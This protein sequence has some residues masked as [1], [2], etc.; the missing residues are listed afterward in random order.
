MICCGGGKYQMHFHTKWVIAKLSSTRSWW[1]TVYH[2]THRDRDNCYYIT[3]IHAPS[4]RLLRYICVNQPDSTFI[5]YQKANHRL[6]IR[7][8]QDLLHVVRDVGRCVPITRHGVK[9][10]AD[11]DT[12]Y[13]HRVNINIISIRRRFG[14]ERWVY[15]DM[16]TQATEGLTGRTK[17]LKSC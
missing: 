6:K 3:S 15:W 17:R 16:P 9:N 13:D 5:C 11:R 8:Y 7:Q 2:K 10:W 12:I 1:A 4:A 14:R